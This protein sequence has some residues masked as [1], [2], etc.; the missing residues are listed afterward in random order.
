MKKPEFRVVRENDQFKIEIQGFFSTGWFKDTAKNRK[1]ILVFLR[2]LYDTQT[3]KRIFTLEQLAEVVG[4]KNRQAVDSH[5]KAFRDTQGNILEYLNHK[6]KV[7]ERVIEAVWVAFSKGPFVTV[8]DL[9]TKTNELVKDDKNIT[10]ANVR[11]AFEQV[12]GYKVWR[13]MLKKLDKGESHYKESYLLQYL[14]DLISKNGD[15][16][17][18]NQIP[19]AD[20]KPQIEE[21]VEPVK[22]YADLLGNVPEKIEDKL[23]PLLAHVKD[24]SNL[25]KELLSTWEGPL[26][27]VL[28]SFVLYTAGLSYGT[29]GGWIG[30]D[31]S[32]ICRWMVPLSTWSLSWFDRLKVAFSGQVAVDEKFI[33]IGNVTWYLFVAVDCITRCPLHIALYPGNSGAYCLTFLLELK[34]K[35]YFP[36]VIVTDGHDAYIKAIEKAFPKAK[37]MLCRFH[38]IRSVFRRMKTAK[39]FDIKISE[40]IKGIFKGTNRKRTVL[41]RV[42]KLEKKLEEKD[43]VWIIGGLLKK[44]VQVLPA[45][46]N[47]QRWPSTSNSAEWFNGAFDRF[48][49]LKGSFVDEKSAYKQIGLFMLG[50]MFRIGLKGQASPLERGDVNISTIPFYHLVN[51]PNMLKLKTMIA[52]QYKGDN[53][54]DQ[55]KQAA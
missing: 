39:L 20:I 2:E 11:K 14:L 52:D 41:D 29:I 18:A 53:V 7:D 42:S 36:R 32:T 40:M 47:P 16:K 10:E 30:V 17:E 35:G 8:K 54:A 12:S 44:L 49:R 19:H 15:L 4:S 48:Y 38:L 37:H 50:Y 23:K 33:K 27:I 9:T 45:V 21:G 51:R 26:G 34:Q 24:P 13:Q 3:N 6:C 28:L 5:L 55:Y 22:G 1:A 25:Y 31:A 46:Q 43:Q